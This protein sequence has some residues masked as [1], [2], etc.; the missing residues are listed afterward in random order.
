MLFIS[1]S[2][3][4]CEN[5]NTCQPECQMNLGPSHTLPTDPNRDSNQV[6]PLATALCAIIDLYVCGVQPI[7]ARH[8]HALACD[9]HL[10]EEA[11]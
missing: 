6:L 4:Y 3:R 5:C 2:L 8:T 10:R 11:V 9:F 7:G 1:V